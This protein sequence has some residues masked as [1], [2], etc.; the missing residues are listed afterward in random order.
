MSTAKAPSTLL[1]QAREFN[2]AP[3]KPPT[4]IRSR[5]PRFTLEQDVTL[6]LTV[7]QQLAEAM[8]KIQHYDTIYHQW[9]FAAVD[10]TGQGVALNFYGPPGTGKTL[11]AEALAGSLQQP[12]M[13]VSIA[14]LESKFMGETAKNI[15]SLFRQASEEGAILFFDEADT[16]LGKRLSSVTQGIDNEVNAMRSTLLIELEKHQGIAIFATNFVKNYDPAF[17][18]RIT[19]HIGFELPGEAERL[20][21]WSKMLVSGIPLAGDR[22]SYLHELV[23]LSDALSGR[24]IRNCLRLALPKALM[25]EGP[26]RLTLSHLSESIAR[27]RQAYSAINS[28]AGNAAS[29]QIDVAKKLLGVS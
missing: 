6:S 7:Q 17:L 15:A 27:V 1:N 24:D 16:L 13:M 21:I 3:E 2:K 9:G 25:G 22:Q 14:D 8:T 28:G 18:S 11:T 26:P 19:Q 20:A 4:Q 10:P 29:S 5:T 23:M 12:I